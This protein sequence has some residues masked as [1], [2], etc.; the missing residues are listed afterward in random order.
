MAPYL[1]CRHRSFQTVQSST[2]GIYKKCVQA[3]NLNCLVLAFTKEGLHYTKQLIKKASQHRCSWAWNL[4]YLSKDLLSL[5]HCLEYQ[6]DGNRSFLERNSLGLVP[7]DGHLSSHCS[8]AALS[9]LMSLSS[10]YNENKGSLGQLSCLVFW[11]T[12]Y[13]KLMTY[14]FWNRCQLCTHRSCHCSFQPVTY[15]EN[16][17]LNWQPGHTKQ[18]ILWCGVTGCQLN[19]RVLAYPPLCCKS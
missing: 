12:V 9:D 5:L 8:C 19:S 18:L 11:S 17:D 15:I 13:C 16:L 1:T 14:N 7:C 3:V 2:P 10:N 6:K 4:M